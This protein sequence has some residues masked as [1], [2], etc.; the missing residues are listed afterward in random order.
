[1]MG[2][3]GKYHTLLI[4]LL[5][6]KYEID[7]YGV[8]YSADVKSD[9]SNVII[10]SPSDNLWYEKLNSLIK[11]NNYAFIISSVFGKN[12]TKIDYFNNKVIYIQHLNTKFLFF[13]SILKLC[14]LFDK[15]IK[16]AVA[17]DIHNKKNLSLLFKKHWFSV[18]L[19]YEGD[20]VTKSPNPSKVI[21]SCGRLYAKQKNVNFLLKMSKYANFEIWL[22]GPSSVKQKEKYKNVKSFGAYNHSQLDEIYS[23]PI[24]SIL[25]SK[26]EGFGFCLVES[27]QHSTPIIVRHTF[28]AAKYLTNE[29]KNGLLLNRFLTP[30][31]AAKKINKWLEKVDYQTVSNN[32]LNFAKNNLSLQQFEKSWENII[33]FVLNDK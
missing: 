19:P 23:K 24:A 25:V 32:C 18:A 22:Y 5:Y 13:M 15:Q 8:S 31:L 1:M 9:K 12:S 3:T 27:L 28:S 21:V 29:N 2:G 26:F 7:E 14:P 16:Y 33:D 20:L 4:N 11:N 6:K 30:Y 10:R 17:Y